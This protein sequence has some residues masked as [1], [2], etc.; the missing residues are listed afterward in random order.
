MQKRQD[1]AKSGRARGLYTAFLLRENSV[2]DI[3]YKG[4][5]E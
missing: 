3:N 4:D 2:E 5:K 1:R